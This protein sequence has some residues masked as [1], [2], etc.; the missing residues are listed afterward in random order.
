M[1]CAHTQQNPPHISANCRVLE[2]KRPYSKA[3]LVFRITGLL[4]AALSYWCG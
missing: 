2:G 4:R 3:D 1:W